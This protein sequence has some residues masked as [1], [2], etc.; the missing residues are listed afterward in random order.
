[1]IILCALLTTLGT[2]PVAR[3]QADDEASRFSGTWRGDS[4]CVAKNT[5]CHDE[6]VVYRIQKL[7]ARGHVTISADKIVSGK[8]INM[9]N[10]EFHYD[11]QL[12]SWMCQYPQGVWRLTVQDTKV[13]GTLTEHDGTLFRQIT[14]HKDP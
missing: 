10:L 1:V 12:K 11:Q 4:V 8:A 7:P 5:A 3:S 13:E 14:L 6:V 2:A 9:G